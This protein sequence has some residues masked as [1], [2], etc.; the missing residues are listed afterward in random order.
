[1]LNV[2]NGTGARSSQGRQ[3]SQ[4][5]YPRQQGQHI[6]FDVAGKAERLGL[7]PGRLPKDAPAKGVAPELPKSSLERVGTR[8]RSQRMRTVPGRASDP[9][10]NRQ[11]PIVADRTA[12]CLPA[13]AWAQ[14][15]PAGGVD[16]ALPAGPC[17]FCPLFAG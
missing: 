17:L 16:H 9:R 6:G 4:A 5:I 11:S 14:P 13:F 12:L 10:P 15:S 7:P 1:M 8:D 3:P 2:V